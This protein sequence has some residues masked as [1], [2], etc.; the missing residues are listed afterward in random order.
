MQALRTSHGRHGVTAEECHVLRHA[1]SG[2]PQNIA[3]RWND[4]VILVEPRSR[5]IEQAVAA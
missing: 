4:E 1:N 5:R 3:A 2:F